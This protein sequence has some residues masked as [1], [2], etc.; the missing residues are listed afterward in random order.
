MKSLYKNIITAVFSVL[1][2]ESTAQDTELNVAYFIID[3]TK[4]YEI[5]GYVP[6]SDMLFYSDNGG[7]N[8]LER[9]TTETSG[10][11]KLYITD[12]NTEPA[13][14]LN[15]NIKN[16]NGISGSGK[17]SVLKEPEFMF[18]DLSINEVAQNATLTW[19]AAF[20]SSIPYSF[21]VL[22]VME[23]GDKKIIAT[24]PS[25]NYTTPHTYSFTDVGQKAKTY[26]LQIRQEDRVRY[27]TSV[28]S[29]N[30][31]AKIRLYP[32]AANSMVTLELPASQEVTNYRLTDIHG[33]TV[34]HG[35]VSAP[36]T[37]ID[38][39]NLSSGS[40]YVHIKDLSGD[41]SLKFI[42]L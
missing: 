22:R 29:I 36:K 19:E 26:E 35:L 9:F 14:L 7:G 20:Y 23:N 42:K 17:V 21:D 4:V 8:M 41:R 37:N 28:S 38:V 25:Q 27:S 5:T 18:K 39:Q 24:V 10:D 33:R 31:E 40:Y 2:L 1:I 6:G 13:F 16:E 30:K 32:T 3:D 11:R 12:K 15:T 34:K